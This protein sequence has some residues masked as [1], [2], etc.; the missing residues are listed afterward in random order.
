MTRLLTAAT[1]LLCVVAFTAARPA[2]QIPERFTN[3]QILPKDMARPALVSVMRSFAMHLGVRCEHC[4]VGEGSD[5]STFDFAADTKP[6]KL[7]ARKMMRLLETINGEGLKDIGDPA[8]QPK[9]TCYTCHRG[10]K[11]PLTVPP[12]GGGAR[13]RP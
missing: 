12:S 2:A 6:T 1:V 11:Q 13:P 10:A 3:L 4:H 7:T 8:R 5:L 9:V